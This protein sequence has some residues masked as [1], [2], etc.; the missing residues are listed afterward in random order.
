[1]VAADDALFP[2]QLT[3]CSNRTAETAGTTLTL[4]NGLVARTFVI[5]SATV[6]PNA[7]DGAFGTID[8][9]NERTSQSAL[10]HILPEAAL[11]LDGEDFT[12]GGLFIGDARVLI[13]RPEFALEAA[14]DSSACSFEASMCVTNNMLRGCPCSYRATINFVATLKAPSQV[15]GPDNGQHAF[16]NRSGL[17]ALLRTMPNAWRYKTHSVSV[18]RPDLPWVPARCTF[19]EIYTRGCLWIPH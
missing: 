12:L 11:Q 10:R 7:G 9:V 17:P 15:D 13:F 2:A 5:T 14:T 1:L 8:L 18:P 3:V 6:A 19:F 4:S 16:L